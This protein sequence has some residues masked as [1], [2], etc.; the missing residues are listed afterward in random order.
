MNS[1]K[2]TLLFDGDCHF[3]RCSVQRWKKATGDR[4]DYRPSLTSLEAVQ[5]IETDGKIYNGAEAVFRLL[6][7]TSGWKRDFLKLYEKFYIFA[8][9]SE[10]FYRV[11]ARHRRFFSW[12][13]RCH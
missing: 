4:I 11:I 7:Y 2:P 3:C 12:L 1:P 6:T 5:L 10:W 9:T 8:T 13:V